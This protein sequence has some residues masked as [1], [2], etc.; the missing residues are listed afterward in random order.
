MGIAAQ[1]RLTEF[2]GRPGIAVSGELGE[3]N[4]GDLESAL[5]EASGEGRSVALDLGECTVMDSKA[6]DVIVRAATRLWEDGGQLTLYNARGP[7]RE[8]LRIT[9]LTG[10]EGLAL[11]T[12]PPG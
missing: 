2:D 1:F 11:H 3:S 8:L 7:V 5:R 4:C 12:D 6:L 9:G 10:W